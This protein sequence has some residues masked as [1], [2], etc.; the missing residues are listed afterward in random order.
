M[1]SSKPFVQKLIYSCT[2]KHWFVCTQNWSIGVPETL[3]ERTDLFVHKLIYSSCTGISKFSVNSLFLKGQ[4]FLTGSERRH[5]PVPTRLLRSNDTHR[6]GPG[7]QSCG[8]CESP[9]VPDLDLCR[10]LVLAR[11]AVD[12]ASHVKLYFLV[13]TLSFFDFVRIVLTVRSLRSN[14]TWTVTTS[15]LRTIKNVLRVL[16]VTLSNAN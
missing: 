7:R 8:F 4:K 9:F 15:L 16:N 3:N 2:G 10:R 6:Q 12:S 1:I 11:D 5:V 13:A 14:C